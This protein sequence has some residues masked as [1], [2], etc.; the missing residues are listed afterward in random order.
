MVLGLREVLGAFAQFIPGLNKH[1]KNG[2]LMKILIFYSQ[3]QL[4]HHS[5]YHVGKSLFP[6]LFDGKEVRHA[7]MFQ[8]LQTLVVD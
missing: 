5:S 2:A 3:H 4:E 6:G 7:L 1:V 8:H